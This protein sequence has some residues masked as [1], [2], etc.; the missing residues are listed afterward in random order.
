[1]NSPPSP[2]PN[3]NEKSESFFDYIG[4]LGRRKKIK[5]GAEGEL[6]LID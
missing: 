2:T 3:N 6:I 4:T 1:M 5:E